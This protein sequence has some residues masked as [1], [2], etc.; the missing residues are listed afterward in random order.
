M[1]LQVLL[2]P[3]CLFL[4]LWWFL[5]PPL[6][7]CRHLWHLSIRLRLALSLGTAL[8]QNSCHIHLAKKFLKSELNTVWMAQ[9][10]QRGSILQHVQLLTRSLFLEFAQQFFFIT[11]ANWRVAAYIPHSLC[12]CTFQCLLNSCYTK[13]IFNSDTALP[14][15]KEA[16]VCLTDCRCLHLNCFQWVPFTLRR[17]LGSPHC[18]IKTRMD[19]TVIIGLWGGWVGWDHLF[20]FIKDHLFQPHLL[21]LPREPSMPTGTSRTVPGPH[22][23]FEEFWL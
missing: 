13:C 15:Y 21:R 2:C 14:V 6:L 11:A 10:K 7:C 4:F 19:H 9:L 22:H 20:P 18:N 8:S 17:E 16:L 3:G 23:Q 1:V 12:S 5:S